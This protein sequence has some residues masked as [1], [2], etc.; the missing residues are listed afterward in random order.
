MIADCFPAVLRFPVEVKLTDAE[1]AIA[2]F[3]GRKRRRTNRGNAIVDRQI[4]D[5]DPVRVDI[6][7]AVAELA[8]SRV[9]CLAPDLDTES[10]HGSVD[11]VLPS[12]RSVDVK[13]TEWRD[14]N[15]NLGGRLIMPAYKVR[16]E[17]LP[18]VIVLA[19]VAMSGHEHEA[20]SHD[21]PAPT[22]ELVGY[23]YGWELVDDSRLL[24]LRKPTY[25]MPNEDL[26]TEL[27]LLNEADDA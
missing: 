14:R 8:F 17:D 19:R 9:S 7:G 12:G 23:A 3:L 18:D 26:H 16:L 10:R 5:A 4:G 20:P 11:A 2:H 27:G 6:L 21:E 22:V 24:D 1:W 13:A 15:G 25:V